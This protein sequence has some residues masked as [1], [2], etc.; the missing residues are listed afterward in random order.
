MRSFFRKGASKSN[1]NFLTK[2][3]KRGKE[4]GEAKK[5]GKE[6]LREGG[7]RRK[8]KREEVRFQPVWI[9]G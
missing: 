6:G 3:G 5:I 2:R 7:K 4:K 8:K 9:S 1:P